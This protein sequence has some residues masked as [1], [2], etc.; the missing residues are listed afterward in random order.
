MILKELKFN[1]TV[2]AVYPSAF[3]QNQLATEGLGIVNCDLSKLN[4]GFLGGFTRLREL[5]IE[6]FDNFAT[7]FNTSPSTSLIALSWLSL[8]KLSDI[9]TFVTPNLNY[10]AVVKNGVTYLSISNVVYP[11]T[12]TDTIIQDFLAYWITPSFRKTLT[13]LRFDQN[14][15]TK[16]PSEIAKYNNLTN[17]TISRN[18]RLWEVQRNAFNMT[19][20]TTKN[21]RRL[22]MKSSKI[23]YI[24]PGDFQG[25][26]HTC[27]SLMGRFLQLH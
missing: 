3:C 26:Y 14:S 8:G 27:A 23:A 18:T 20:N 17:V 15:M 9:N 11:S 2:L 10:P 12:R 13:E 21:P 5:K 24:Q 6:N 7:T 16:V 22:Y 19:K 4:W 25:N 1:Q